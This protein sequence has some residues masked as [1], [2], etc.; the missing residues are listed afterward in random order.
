MTCRPPFWAGPPSRGWRASNV[1]L[2]SDVLFQLPPCD[3]EGIRDG[4]VGV[5]VARVCCMGFAG[6][7]MLSGDVDLYSHAVAPSPRVVL[8]RQIEEN[9]AAHEALEDAVKLFE[10]G[11]YVGLECRAGGHSVEGDPKGCFHGPV[12][13]RQLCQWRVQ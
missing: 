5:F 1:L 4:S 8:M 13:L 10:A 12:L 3:P 2:S 9:A 6:N 7:Q 11:A